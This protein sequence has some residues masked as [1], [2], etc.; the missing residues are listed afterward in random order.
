M[1]LKQVGAE[2]VTWLRKHPQ[3]KER[4]F[5]NL[6]KKDKLKIRRKFLGK[7][8]MIRYVCHNKVP[9]PFTFL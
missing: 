1:P 3:Q 5:L 4:Y 6:Y 7:H 8:F 2:T 9:T